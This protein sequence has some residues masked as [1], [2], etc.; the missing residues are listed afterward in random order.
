[1]NVHRNDDARSCG[2]STVVQNQST[3]FCNEKLWAVK[4][5]VNSHGSGGLINSG[6]TVFVEGIEVII[7]GDSAQP[8]DLCPIVGGPHCNPFAVG[9]SD[10]VFAY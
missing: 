9:C 3:V 6:S 1:M 7:K 8:D 5:T 4:D 2:A 10:N